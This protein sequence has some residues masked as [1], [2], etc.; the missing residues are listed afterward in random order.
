MKLFKYITTYIVTIKDKWN[1]E[2]SY[3]NIYKY[4]V[5]KNKLYLYSVDSEEFMFNL[6]Y[7]HSYNIVEEL[8]F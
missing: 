1:N 3:N 6:T 5:R 4:K 7:I 8:L 2:N